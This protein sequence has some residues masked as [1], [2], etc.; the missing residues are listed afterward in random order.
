MNTQSLTTIPAA[1]WPTS[2]SESPNTA[3]PSLR[4]MLEA[5]DKIDTSLTTRLATSLPAL[6]DAQRLVGWI[7]RRRAAGDTLLANEAFMA[8]KRLMGLFP[9]GGYADPTIFAD[10]LAALLS[11]YDRHFVEAVCSPVSGVATRTKF[12][13]TLETVKAALEEEKTKRA[14]IEL[15]TRWVIKEHARLAREAEERRQWALTPEQ[16]AERRAFA[17]RMLTKY[18]TERSE[19]EAKAA[20]SATDEIF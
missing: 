17:E 7:E 6:T 3:P 16:I 20:G 10:G 9:A 14:R 19:D 2:M 4:A 15:R 13:L 12:K 18:K 1:S 11:A 5:F 8:A